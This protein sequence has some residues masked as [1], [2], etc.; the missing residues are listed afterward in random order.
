MG[1]TNTLSFA[2]EVLIT[3]AKS[4]KRQN[5]D[6]ERKQSEKITF[7]AVLSVITQH[8]ERSH[9]LH[10]GRARLLHLKRSCERS[11]KAICPTGFS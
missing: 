8:T 2:T 11:F 9:L 10:Q 3:T 5:G 6:E 1:L 4:F 7:D